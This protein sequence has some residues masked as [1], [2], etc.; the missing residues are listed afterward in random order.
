MARVIKENAKPISQIYNERQ[1]LKHPIPRPLEITTTKVIT[2]LEW[3][4]F[5]SKLENH[6]QQS[7]EHKKDGTITF[8]GEYA[9]DAALAL[10]HRKRF[11]G[12]F[13]FIMSCADKSTALESVKSANQNHLDLSEIHYFDDKL[14]KVSV[15]GKENLKKML[16]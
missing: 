13:H 12:K 4:K 5:Y 7:C 6:L 10:Q 16:T 9:L 1:H 8:L 2:L 11:N 14:E 3:K 15:S